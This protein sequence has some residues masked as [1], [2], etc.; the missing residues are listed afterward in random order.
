MYVLAV[1]LLPW[2]G[3]TESGFSSLMFV[4]NSV[5]RGSSVFLALARSLDKLSLVQ[6]PPPPRELIHHIHP[7][8]G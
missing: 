2:G 8:H 4:R 7:F 1:A 6:W 3:G 5:S